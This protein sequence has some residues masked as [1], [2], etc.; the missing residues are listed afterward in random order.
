MFKIIKGFHNINAE[1]YIIF[2]RSNITRCHT[3]KIT[4]KRFTSNKAKRFFF[5][6][7]VNVWNS[8]PA[9]VVDSKTIITF[10]NRLDKYLEANLQLKYYPLT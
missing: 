10:K 7:F 1:D 2:D 4:D 5:N 6:R 8:L 9:N 3:F